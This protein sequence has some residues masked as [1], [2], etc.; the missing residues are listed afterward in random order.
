MDCWKRSK[1][2]IGVEE[3]EKKAGHYKYI[4][5]TKMDESTELQN[6]EY[7][8]AHAAAHHYSI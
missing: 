8:G 7:R 2:E 6:T 5:V 4:F 1:F 3:E